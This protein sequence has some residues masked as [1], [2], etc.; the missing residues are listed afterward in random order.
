MRD[1]RFRDEPYGCGRSL[2][3]YPHGGVLC[4][5]EPVAKTEFAEYYCN[6]AVCPIVKFEDFDSTRCCPLCGKM[7]ATVRVRITSGGDHE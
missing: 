1:C 7:G 4:D 2:C 6:K 5:P 3:G